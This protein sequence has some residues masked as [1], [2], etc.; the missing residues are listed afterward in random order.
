MILRPYDAFTKSTY[1]RTFVALLLLLSASRFVVAQESEPVPPETRWLS[2]ELELGLDAIRSKSEGDL[3]LDQVLRLRADP[4]KHDNLHF[5]STIWTTQDLDGRESSTSAFR[6]LN[7]TSDTF[8][9][10]RVLSLY[11]EYEGEHDDVRLRLGRQRISGGVAYN[12]IDG[13]YFRMRHNKWEYYAFL[14]ARA[15][16]YENSHED[17]SSGAGA[18][19]RPLPRTRV[20]LDLFYGD[21]DRRNYDADD[22]SAAL[23]SVS[24]RHSLNPYHNVFGRA[25]WYEEDLD[26]FKVMAQGVFREDAFL[27]TVAYRK[28]VSTLAERPTDF[29][30]FYHVVGELNGYEDVQAIVGFPIGE[31]VELGFEAQV[32]DASDDMLNTGNRDFQRYGISLDITDIAKHYGLR[33]IAELWDASDAESEKTISGEVSRRWE[34][35]KAS[36]GVDYDRFQD[37]IIQYDLQDQDSFFIQSASDIY[38]FYLRVKHDI[39]EQHSVRIRGS[40]EDDDTDEAP[41]WR[42]RS[43]YT[44]RF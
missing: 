8:V 14:G 33:V 23:T 18:A 43:V 1:T 11:M 17:I 4:A 37:R 34:R 19:W 21:D 24:V 36:M 41:Y 2:G 27:Y 13:A 3:E 31:H 25:I 7:D 39:N 20:A 29:P 6:G 12:R 15:S 35:T 40:V 5:R 26:E 28:R 9:N 16:V 10:T 32:H 42:L 44:Y 22:V 30:Q 38:T